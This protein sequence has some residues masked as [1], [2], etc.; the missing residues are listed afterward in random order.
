MEQDNPTIEQWRP[1]PGWEASHEVSSHGRVRTL[2]RLRYT[3]GLT[4]RGKRPHLA[5]TNWPGRILA[6]DEVSEQ[7]HARVMLCDGRRTEIMLVYRAVLLAFVGPCPP[8]M[9]CCHW[10]NNARN[11]KLT[12]LRW[13]TRAGNRQDSI[14]A[15]TI[16][17]GSR[18]HFAKLNEAQ[19][20]QIRRLAKLG[21]T[22]AAIAT[23][24]GV[25]R[26]SIRRITSG[27]TWRHV[28]EA[29]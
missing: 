15:G 25:A 28:P 22:P 20:P 12:N 1:V 29:A 2:G 26:E 4:M 7:G 16:A 17:R 10:D 18:S 11:N 24:Y 21:K 19:I 8:G 23:A 27:K 14:R 5:W 13:D 6:P 9:E 3:P